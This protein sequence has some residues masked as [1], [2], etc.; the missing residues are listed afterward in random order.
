MLAAR[1]L[2]SMCAL[3]L[4]RLTQALQ[5]TEYGEGMSLSCHIVCVAPTLVEF[6]AARRRCVCN[7]KMVLQQTDAGAILLQ[8]ESWMSCAMGEHGQA[9]DTGR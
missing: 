4:K 3:N 1:T 7:G 5:I 6:A 8:S 9:V 2:C